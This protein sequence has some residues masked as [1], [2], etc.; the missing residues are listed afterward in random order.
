MSDFAWYSEISYSSD[1]TQGDLLVQCPIPFPNAS[2]YK[3]I[4]ENEATAEAPIDI[5]LG[6]LVV[7]SQACDLVNE[8]F[9]KI[10]R[11]TKNIFDRGQK[12]PVP[13]EVNC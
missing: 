6:N 3:A 1:L 11:T 8:K 12:P 7:L 10:I 2:M 5:K 13:P 4:L 9:Q